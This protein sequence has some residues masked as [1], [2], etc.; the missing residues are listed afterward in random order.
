MSVV[1]L[2]HLNEIERQRYMC[3]NLS[4][5]VDGMIKDCNTSASNIIEAL[6][7]KLE[8][9]GDVMYLKT[10]NFKLREELSEARRK[11]TRQDQEMDDLRRSI[12]NLEKEVKA[13]KEGWGPFPQQIELSSNMKND[14]DSQPIKAEQM[15]IQNKRQTVDSPRRHITS[16]KSPVPGCSKDLDYMQREEEDWPHGPGSMDWTTAPP[17]EQVI[18]ADIR[19]RSVINV[20]RKRVQDSGPEVATSSFVPRRKDIKI[21]ENRLLVPPLLHPVSHGKTSHDDGGEWRSAPKRVNKIQIP[22]IKTS[23][24]AGQFIDTPESGSSAFGFNQNKVKT[25]KTKSTTT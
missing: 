6:V 13:L 18:S 8:S 11:I 4:G 15:H 23:L 3:G 24:N 2:A 19:K 12:I 7:E 21:I 17:V 5:K 16:E 22:E 25:N 9:T 1:G 10:Q 14:A 20:K